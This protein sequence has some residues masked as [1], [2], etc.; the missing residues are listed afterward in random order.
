MKIRAKAFE[1]QV[2]CLSD[3]ER[4][5]IWGAGRDGKK[6]FGFLSV[7]SQKKVNNSR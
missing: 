6:V 4:F 3:W 2:L 7:E 5:T 1:E